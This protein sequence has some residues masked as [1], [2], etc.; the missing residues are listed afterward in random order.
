MATSKHYRSRAENEDIVCPICMDIYDTPKMLEC[1]HSFCLECIFK[2]Y[3]G[4]YKSDDGEHQVPCPVCRNMNKLSKNDANQLT[5]DEFNKQ[6]HNSYSVLSLMEIR[7]QLNE[8]S[9]NFKS[10]IF[11]TAP[12]DSQHENCSN[13][14]LCGTKIT[15]FCINCNVSLCN[16]C[17]SEH[18]DAHPFHEL[19]NLQDET[20]L[21]SSHTGS[22]QTEIATSNCICNRKTNWVC[23]TCNTS[24]C[25]DCFPEHLDA[26]DMHDIKEVLES[27]TH[28]PTFTTTPAAT[29]TVSP[30]TLEIASAPIAIAPA[31]VAHQSAT[32]A[33]ELNSIKSN[34]IL[35]YLLDGKYEIEANFNSY[36]C[37]TI[38]DMALI[39]KSDGALLADS[40]SIRGECF[41]TNTAE[42]KTFCTSL[43]KFPSSSNGSKPVIFEKQS[44][45]TIMCIN[46]DNEE[47]FLGI[48]ECAGFII[49][50]AGSQNLLLVIFKGPKADKR[51]LNRFVQ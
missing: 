4:N 48:R 7:A 23:S 18:C 25:N 45:Q 10:T 35:N 46:T 47:T 50:H 30:T 51:F 42:L 29:L 49:K 31:A 20:K 17:L 32:G 6:L 26:F 12:V 9:S 3:E 36:H 41:S 2:T 28:S 39:R 19:K 38:C 40:K 27:A 15:W 13:I 16:D 11:D 14:C 33:T 8:M 21:L 44:Y 1:H 43:P 37:N 34:K 5:M 24:L 22:A